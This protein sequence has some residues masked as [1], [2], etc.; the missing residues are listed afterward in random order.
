MS[1]SLPHGEATYHITHKP[2]DRRSVDKKETGTGRAQES[3]KANIMM[4]EHPN[5]LDLI[6]IEGGEIWRL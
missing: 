4:P 1:L 3:K 6:A 5:E 2:T